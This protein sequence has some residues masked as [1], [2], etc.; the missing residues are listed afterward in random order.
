MLPGESRFPSPLMTPRKTINFGGVKLTI[1]LLQ[2]LFFS[3]SR[4]D[5]TVPDHIVNLLEASL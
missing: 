5:C 2:N 1:F 4:E 3:L